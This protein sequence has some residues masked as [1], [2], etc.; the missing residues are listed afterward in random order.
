MELGYRQQ[1]WDDNEED[2]EIEM[3]EDDDDELEEDVYVPSGWREMKRR[4]VQVGKAG[5]AGETTT[6]LLMRPTIPRSLELSFACRQATARQAQID[7]DIERLSA[8]CQGSGK[9]DLG[10]REGKDERDGS[11]E[12]RAALDG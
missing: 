8:G 1:R 10:R 9:G 6:S 12:C 7:R 2:D 3:G 11:I 4:K 5:A